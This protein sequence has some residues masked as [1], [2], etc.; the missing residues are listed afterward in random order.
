MA[1]AGSG[2]SDVTVASLITLSSGRASPGLAVRTSDD[3]NGII[4]SMVVRDGANRSSLHSISG[5]AYTLLAQQTDAGLRLGATYDLEVTADGRDI[6]VRL[7]GQ[8]ALRHRLDE[9]IASLHAGVTTHGLRVMSNGTADD[10]G[11]SW[12]DI[13]IRAA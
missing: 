13:V 12:N 1:L 11:S 9:S 8:T 2:T 10:G 5:G 7:D 4:V 6:V 3:E